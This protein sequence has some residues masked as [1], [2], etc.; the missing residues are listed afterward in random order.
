MQM[1]PGENA[2]ADRDPS[3]AIDARL[4]ALEAQ[5]QTQQSRLQDYERALVERIADVDDDRRRAA[6]QLKRAIEAARGDQEQRLRHRTRWLLL[7]LVLALAVALAGLSLAVY[8]D[9]ERRQFAGELVQVREEL[10]RLSGLPAGDPALEGRVA[11]VEVH[12]SELSGRLTSVAGEVERALAAAAAAERIARSEER[13]RLS[14]EIERLE[15]VQGDLAARLEAAQRELAGRLDVALQGASGEEVAEEALPEAVAGPSEPFAA[16]AEPLQAEPI[17]PP[18]IEPAPSPEAQAGVEEDSE[19]PSV[20]AEPGT[21]PPT[22]VTQTGVYALQ[23]IGFHD[24]E[25]FR[26]FA[27]EARLP[28]PV[29]RLAERYLGRPWYP[30]IAGLYP[31]YAAAQAAVAQ[32]PGALRGLDPWIRPL[33]EGTELWVVDLTMEAPG[34]NP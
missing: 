30:L 29:W 24:L 32:L 13:A 26:E 27:L 12:L 6:A 21:I 10:R 19:S 18:A 4:L 15:T 31:D 33:P 22:L 34:P 16:R 28:A 3:G 9:Q 11:D 25:R 20:A 2:I 1:N 17:L 8:L 5:T 23:L 14:G 7:G